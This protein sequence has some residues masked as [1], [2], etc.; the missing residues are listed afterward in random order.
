MEIDSPSSSCG[1]TVEDVLGRLSVKTVHIPG[2]KRE[3][4]RQKRE[5]GLVALFDCFRVVRR[6][7]T[8]SGHTQAVPGSPVVEI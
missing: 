7:S 6:V 3:G 4:G 5:W 2:R 1:E 8:T